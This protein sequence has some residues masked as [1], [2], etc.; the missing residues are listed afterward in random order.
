M[1][2]MLL[3]LLFFLGLFASS[4]LWRR[5]CR[6][7]VQ[8]RSLYPPRHS[9][10]PPCSLEFVS[11][12]THANI[13]R[14]HVFRRLS[15]AVSFAFCFSLMSRKTTRCKRASQRTADVPRRC[16]RWW[17]A[18]RCRRSAPCERRDGD[19]WCRRRRWVRRAA[20][21]QH[22]STNFKISIIAHAENS[23]VPFT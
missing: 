16:W 1:A 11:L 20:Y 3:A 13:H 14:C 9:A 15:H 5:K 10:Q 23:S 17:H 6:W 22:K 7:V 19:R 18:T 21:T 12:T 8:S 2:T 4:L